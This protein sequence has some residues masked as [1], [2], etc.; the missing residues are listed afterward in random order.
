MLDA[1]RGRKAARDLDR[2]VKLVETCV[3]DRMSAATREQ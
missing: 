1:A 2:R 3:T